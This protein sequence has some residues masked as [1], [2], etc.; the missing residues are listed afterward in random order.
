MS[1]LLPSEV[2][3]ASFWGLLVT[4]ITGFGVFCLVILSLARPL[5]PNPQ[6]KKKYLF[7]YFKI[8]NSNF[9]TTKLC[10]Y[11]TTFYRYN[12]KINLGVQPALHGIL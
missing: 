5:V 4:K 3:K 12:I 2:V 10:F 1:Y 7:S 11:V 8:L 6:K 9:V